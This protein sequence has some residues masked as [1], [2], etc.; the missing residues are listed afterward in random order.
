MLLSK[1][2]AVMK[3][4]KTNCCQIDGEHFAKNLIFAN[5]YCKCSKMGSQ[6]LQISLASSSEIDNQSLTFSHFLLNQAMNFYN[7]SF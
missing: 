4:F 6:N 2:L 3:I 1:V 7:V 5:S